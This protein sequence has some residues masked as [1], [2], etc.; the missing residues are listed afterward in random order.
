M[1]VFKLFCW[2]LNYVYATEMLDGNCRAIILAKKYCLA[3][4]KI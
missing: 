4:K 1:L 3:D 2:A